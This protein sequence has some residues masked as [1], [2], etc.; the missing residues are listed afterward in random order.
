MYPILDTWHSFK[1]IIQQ[2][3]A[4]KFLPDTL[5]L[6]PVDVIDSNSEC[7]SPNLQST[8]HRVSLMA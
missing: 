6:D 2:N 1:L 5:S 7:D 8:L 4:K 3:N